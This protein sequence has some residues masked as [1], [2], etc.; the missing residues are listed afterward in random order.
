MLRE[1]DIINNKQT[2]IRVAEELITEEDGSITNLLRDLENNSDFFEAP[3]STRFHS[4]YKGGLCQHSLNV[5]NNLFML[6]DNLGLAEE[7]S[8]RSIIIAA[9]FHD[10]SK[11]NFY[12]L[13]NR[14]VKN[15]K[16]QWES[17]P[18]YKVREANDRFLC[19]SHAVNSYYM[20]SK[21]IELSDEEAAA[22]MN[23]HGGFDESV[24]SNELSMIYNRYR[25]CSLLSAADL[26]AVY[27]SERI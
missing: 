11:A 8:R 2:F 10:I 17:V 9:L 23:H 6:V 22:I 3:A 18:E 24:N 21:F 27:Q 25:L 12:T 13:Y 5:L 20:L 1:Q 4:A 15:D 19:H 26:L 7:I 16:G 14:N